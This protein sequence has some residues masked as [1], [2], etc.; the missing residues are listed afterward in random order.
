MKNRWAWASHTGTGL[1]LQEL[2]HENDIPL[3][4]VNGPRA[5]K[6]PNWTTPN[7]LHALNKSHGSVSDLARPNQNRPRR[8]LLYL[9][10]I[11]E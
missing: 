10:P 6:G 5:I 4:A 8:T 7:L 11:P 1:S 3:K 9:H 2:K